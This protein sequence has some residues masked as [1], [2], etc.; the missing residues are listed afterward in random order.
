MA[1]IEPNPVY[2]YNLTFRD[3]QVIGAVVGQERMEKKFTCPSH[4]HGGIGEGFQWQNDGKGKSLTYTVTL[5]EI[6]SGTHAPKE[7]DYLR[8]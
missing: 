3:C 5:Q 2:W 4:D 8:R 1:C 6:L 7:I